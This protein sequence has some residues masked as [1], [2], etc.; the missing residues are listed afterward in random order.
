MEK[1]IRPVKR[2]IAVHFIGAD[3]MV[4]PDAVFPAGIHQNGATYD[5]CLKKNSR[6]LDRSVHMGFGREVHYNVRLLI[7]EDMIYGITIPDICLIESEVIILHYRLKRREVPGVGETVY[8]YYGILRMCLHF[9]KDKI[10]SD[11]SGSAGDD[12]FH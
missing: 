5:I 7:L 8:A 11:K 10:A 2:Q 4:S 9:I 6:I 12:Y 1:Q 3:L